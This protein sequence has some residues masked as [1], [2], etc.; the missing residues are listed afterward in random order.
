MFTPLVG[1]VASI[2]AASSVAP[3]PKS[4]EALIEAVQAAERSGD[5]AALTRLT[6]Q[7]FV[8][9]HATGLIESRVTYLASRNGKAA[10]PA[11]GRGFLE[12]DVQ[13]RRAGDTA[14]RTAITRIRG[15][16]AGNDVW[17]RST[18]VVAREGGA[19]R[20]LDLDSALLVQAPIYDGPVD[21]QFPTAAFASEKTGAFHFLVRGGQAYLVFADGRESPLIPIGPETFWYGAGS[22]LG[23]A[24]DSAGRVTSV[25]RKNGVRVAWVATPSA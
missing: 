19:W 8:Q 10:D 17:V 21:E 11:G 7:Q 18:A 23:I 5:A 15:A 16:T 22:T 1:F 6:S 9:E 2:A 12:R 3:Q 14:I 25:T 13:W 24:R 4:P 20:L